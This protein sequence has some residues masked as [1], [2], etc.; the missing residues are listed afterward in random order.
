MFHDNLTPPPSSHMHFQSS[1]SPIDVLSLLHS[2][3]FTLHISRIFP[4]LPLLDL[5]FLRRPARE[6]NCTLSCHRSDISLRTFHSTSSTQTCHVCTHIQTSLPSLVVHP[7]FRALHS[8]CF[9]YS[10]RSTVPSPF[11]YPHSGATTRGKR[12]LCSLALSLCTSFDID[13]VLSFAN[14]AGPRQTSL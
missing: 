6:I 4:R 12:P 1:F 7:A 11:C 9:I 13:T 3:T 2:L 8:S 10:S 14:M 5:G